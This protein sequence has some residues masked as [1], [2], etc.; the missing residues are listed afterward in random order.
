MCRALGAASP[1]ARISSTRYCWSFGGASSMATPTSISPHIPRAVGHCGFMSCQSRPMIAFRGRH[2]GHDSPGVASLQAALRAV[3]GVDLFLGM[4]DHLARSPQVFQL[5]GELVEL[6]RERVRVPRDVDPGLV[7]I[8]LEEARADRS[9]GAELLHAMD[10]EVV[11]EPG[12]GA[13]GDDRQVVARDDDP[14]PAEVARSATG[15]WSS[16]AERGRH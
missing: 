16:R 10:R 5:V 12:L 4:D 1:L 7:D 14:V 3:G 9:L 13:V 6:G 2:R 15:R 11:D 8:G